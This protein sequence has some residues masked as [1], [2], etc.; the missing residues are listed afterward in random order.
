[1]KFCCGLNACSYCQ[2]RIRLGEIVST[3]LH[4]A[5]NFWWLNPRLPGT[6][7]TGDTY[8]CWLLLK[9]IPSLPQALFS[10]EQHANMREWLF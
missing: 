9:T 10:L 7:R 5:A 8:G 3:N 6:V 1:M 2:N 4:F